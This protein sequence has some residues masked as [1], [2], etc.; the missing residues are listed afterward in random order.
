MDT[1][2]TECTECEERS[3]YTNPV[4][5]MDMGRRSAHLP[6]PGAIGALDPAVEA[7]GT[8]SETVARCSFEAA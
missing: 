2:P 8:P 5:E 7:I 3:H 6:A 1:I 4:T